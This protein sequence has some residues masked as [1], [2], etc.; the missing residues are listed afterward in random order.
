MFERLVFRKKLFKLI[1]DEYNLQVPYYKELIIE[2]LIN[3]ENYKDDDVMEHTLICVN[4]KYYT[5][6]YNNVI[7]KLSQV[8][9]LYKQKAVLGMMSDTCGY[10]INSDILSAGGIYALSFWLITDKTANSDDCIYINHQVNDIKN[11]AL[12]ELDELYG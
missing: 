5:K 3:T 8:N 9:S 2:N 12:M 11:R 6:V 10:E 1:L 4:N 7:C